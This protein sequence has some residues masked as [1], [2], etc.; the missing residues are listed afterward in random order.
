[1]KPS[2]LSESLVQ[3]LFSHR[4]IDIASMSVDELRIFWKPTIQDLHDP[5]LLAGMDLAVERI[6]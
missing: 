2:T 6:L 1:M 3:S 4:G 5:Y